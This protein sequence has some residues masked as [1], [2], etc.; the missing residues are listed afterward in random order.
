MTATTFVL[1]ALGCG[2]GSVLRFWLSTWRRPHHMPWPTV[3]ANVLGTALLGAAASLDDAGHLSA[4][5]SFIIGAGIAGGLT[6]FSTLAVDAVVLWRASRTRAFAYV[7]VT[8]AA[9]VAAGLI[10]W[11]LAQS[12]A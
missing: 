11:W 9:G 8:G 3:L 1:A 2:L 12:F 4:A 10:G 5:G 7:A 6:T